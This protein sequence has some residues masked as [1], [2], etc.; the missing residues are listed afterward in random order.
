[1]PKVF[2][3]KWERCVIHEVGNPAMKSLMGKS[4]AQIAK[5]RG[6]DA[7]DTFLDLAIEDDLNLLY[8]DVEDSLRESLHDLLTARCTPA[9]VIAAYD[10]DRDLGLGLWRSLSV[11]LGLAG[12]LVPQDR[13]GAGA[14]AREAA[15]VLE[16]L[17]RFVAPVPFLTSAVV[18]NTAR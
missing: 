13:D 3:G 9:R 5:E 17:G 4:V 7:I 6:K 12:L 14:T 10:G 2:G 1:M 8:T 15:V 16:E 11:D 18:A